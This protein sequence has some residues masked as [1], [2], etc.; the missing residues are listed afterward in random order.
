MTESKPNTPEFTHEIELGEVGKHGKT[1]RLSANEEERARIAARLDA[2]SVEKLDGEMCISATKS[3]IRVEGKIDAELTR[4]CVAS[5]E[6]M[7]ERVSEDF[8]IDFLREPPE[9]M[10][11]EEDLEAP[12]VH[13]GSRLDLGE[14]LVQ[15]LSL[16]MDPFPRKE[17]VESLAEAYAPPEK[18][19]PFAGLKSILGKDDDNQ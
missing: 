16:A 19:S 4:E 5:L 15:Q 1:F 12:E 18:L 13:E 7:Q 3:A 8:E 10:S 6:P 2:P 9:E 11:E 17:G 14:L